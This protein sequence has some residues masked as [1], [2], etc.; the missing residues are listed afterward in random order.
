MIWGYH[1]FWK[2]PCGYTCNNYD[3]SHSPHQQ[4]QQHH[5]ESMDG[6]RPTPISLG[7]SWPSPNSS[8]PSLGVA[9][10]IYF[11]SVMGYK[12][13]PNQLQLI[14]KF[15]T[16]YICIPGPSK[17]VP[18]GWHLGVIKQPILRVSI[19]THLEGYTVYPN[20]LQTNSEL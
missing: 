10:A 15:D 16:S 11:H 6:D 20:Q 9:I 3:K 17:G 12:I 4:Q 19:F 5:L 7:L 2:H 18:N 14:A 13:Y 1:Y 8:Q